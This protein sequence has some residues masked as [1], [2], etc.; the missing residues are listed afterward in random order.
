MHGSSGRGAVVVAWR[1]AAAAVW[2]VP[3]NKNANAAQIKRSTV[4]DP[5]KTNFLDIDPEPL[6]CHPMQIVIADDHTIF[7]QGLALLLQAQPGFEI[8][9]EVGRLDDLTALMSRVQPDLLLLDYHMPGG[10]PAA[11]L[12]FCKRRYP[13]LKVVALT[14][15][16]SGMAYRQL[17]EAGADAVLL[18]DTTAPMLLRAIADVMNGKTVVPEDVRR[19]ADAADHGLTVR[20]RQILLLIYQG[21]STGKVAEQLRLSVKTVDKHRENLMRKLEVNSVVQL[22]HKARELGVAD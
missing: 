19:E 11:A 10:E 7:R 22:I 8:L 16:R 21:L 1:R 13:D 5:E 6:F 15:A 20:E 14:G 17:I 4:G 3:S 18:K 9:A 2:A 12:G